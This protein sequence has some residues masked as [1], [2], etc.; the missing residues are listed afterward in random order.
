[1]GGHSDAVE[2]ETTS[3]G[4][5][6]DEAYKPTWITRILVAVAVSA[7]FLLSVMLMLQGW[8][9]LGSDAAQG[10]WAFWGN[11]DLL[12]ILFFMSGL[13]LGAGGFL[14]IRGNDTSLVLTFLGVLVFEVV[15]LVAVLG[16]PDA[17][18]RFLFFVVMLPPFFL[19][20]LY[21]VKAVSYWFF[22]FDRSGD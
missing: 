14:A 9:I 10:T 18:T 12:G 17:A 20:L 6:E 2:D 7:S 16:T 3:I 22:S 1:M 15:M 11:T 21:Q 13:S 5:A 8:T 19:L 4:L